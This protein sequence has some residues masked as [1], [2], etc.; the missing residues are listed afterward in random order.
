MTM[1]TPARGPF[2]RASYSSE[3][4]GSAKAGAANAHLA[5]IKRFCVSAL[6]AL[7]AGGAVAGIM[8]LKAAA[9]FWR[10]HY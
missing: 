2:A 1:L 8:A 7:L 5:M 3:L 6:L 10:F 4:R 9:F